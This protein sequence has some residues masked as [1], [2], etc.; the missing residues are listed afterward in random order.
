MK[1]QHVRSNNR[2]SSY[3][4]SIEALGSMPIKAGC[5]VDRNHHKPLLCTHSHDTEDEN[6]RNSSSN[7]RNNNDIRTRDNTLRQMITI[8]HIFI[9]HVVQ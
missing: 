6:S 9:H 3:N 4:N 5:M 7:G 1:P 8:I 2:K